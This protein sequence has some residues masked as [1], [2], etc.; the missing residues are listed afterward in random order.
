M[1]STVEDAAGAQNDQ[2]SDVNALWKHIANVQQEISEISSGAGS[3][4]DPEA[5]V[6]L[7]RTEALQKQFAT[8]LPVVRVSSDSEGFMD[9]KE[10]VTKMQNE[11]KHSVWP[12]SPSSLTGAFSGDDLPIA[13]SPQHE[14]PIPQQEKQPSIVDFALSDSRN[15]VDTKAE[16]AG[17]VDP[18]SVRPNAGKA[19]DKVQF[20]VYAKNFYGIDLFRDNFVIDAVI[21]LKWTDTRVAKL[22]PAGMDELTLSQLVSAKRMWLP[23]VVITNRE[24]KKY[25][26]IS[27]A[28]KINRKGEVLKV[29]RATATVKNKYKL[30]QYPYDEQDLLVKIGSTKYMSDEVVLEPLKEVVV[31]EN[32]LLK[33]YSYDLVKAGATSMEDIDGPMKKSL[34]VLSIT[35]KRKSAE[36]TTKHLL[37]ACLLLV[38]SCGIHYFPFVAPFI[39]P[40]VVLSVFA[41]LAFTKLT[42]V[43]TEVLPAG[44]AFNW[45]DL[46]NQSIL[47]IMFTNI[48]MNIFGEF[49]YHS[50]HCTSFGTTM[51]HECKAMMPI[52]CIVS[53]GTICLAAGPDGL[54]PLTT[55]SIV[56]KSVLIG[57]IGIFILIICKRLTRALANRDEASKAAAADALVGLP[58]LA[59][60]Q[61]MGTNPNLKGSA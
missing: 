58:P 51:N 61:M 45:N 46:I 8:E 25:D 15:Q 11:Q 54:M 50:F 31:L 2:V 44:A 48:G 60:M 57:T 6:L 49:V 56:V 32:G 27:T 40:R 4:S 59:P 7:K 12:F 22:I 37:P 30:S 13:G 19:P 1:E 43:S 55:A 39:T 26:L 18:L 47:M 14:T 5:K 42:I 3:S 17:K 38:I 33:G 16:P 53:L 41:L 20:G 34:G 36:Y 24:M 52:I 28:V 9:A 10:V 29:L 23:A 35:V 21:T